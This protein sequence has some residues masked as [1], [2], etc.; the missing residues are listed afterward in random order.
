MA[1]STDIVGLLLLAG[2]TACPPTP[3]DSHCLEDGACADDTATEDTGPN[4]PGELPPD[5]D[6][7]IARGVRYLADDRLDQ[8]SY[9][10]VVGDVD[11]SGVPQVLVGTPHVDASYDFP[12]LHDT[13]YRWLDGGFLLGP[14]YDGGEIPSVAKATFDGWNIVS[15]STGVSM[16]AV[17]DVTGDGWPDIVC[18]GNYP[19]NV[20]LAAFSGPFLGSHPHERAAA[21]VSVS[22]DAIA[23]FGYDPSGGD[24]S[25]DGIHDLVFGVTPRAWDDGGALAFFGPLRGVVDYTDYDLFLHAP[26][27]EGVGQHLITGDLNADGATDAALNANF[28]PDGLGRVYLAWSP[29]PGVFALHDSDV[30]YSG[31]DGYPG[32][33]MATGG[34]LDGDGATDLVVGAPYVGTRTGRA[35]ALFELAGGA[36]ADAPVTFEARHDGDALGF[37]MTIGDFDGD[38]QAD[39]ALGA[40]GYLYSDMGRPGR[41]LVFRGPLLPGS[42]TEDTADAIWMGSLS[43]DTFGSRLQAGDLDDDG[44]DDLVVGA[45]L[46]PEAGD[47]AGSV[48]ILFGGGL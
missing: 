39:L 44:R 9:A 21:G 43:P 24:L 16:G 46:D 36:L 12:P 20:S 33:G 8:A 7:Q 19:D 5:P 31:E 29:P 38:E 48:T 30:I 11:G 13:G 37:A 42:Y 34:D 17:G 3:K 14:P 47:E 4:T 40:P 15:T 18:V 23:G 26:A 10:L 35:Y 41:V 6:W 22:G 28:G 32:F 1:R 25:G 27:A 45:F 2:L